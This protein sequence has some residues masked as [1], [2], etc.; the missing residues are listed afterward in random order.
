MKPR[1]GNIELLRCVLMFLIVLWHCSMCS[2]ATDFRVAKLLSSL[3]VFAVDA[4]VLIS[5]WLRR[6]VG[7]VI[8]FHEGKWYVQ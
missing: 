6:Y 5:G 7:S 1:D 2:S 3:P 4:F 8:Y